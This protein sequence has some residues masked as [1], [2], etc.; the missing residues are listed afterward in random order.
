MP[1]S[2]YFAPGPL[3][4]EVHVPGSKSET[5]RALVLAALSDTP[6]RI[7][8]ALSSRDS[9][10]MIEALRS[11]G[12]TLD[13]SGSFIQV[14]APPRLR[15][16]EQIDCGLAGTVMRFVPPLCL[17]TEGS[18]L[19]HGD[20]AASQRPMKGLL[21]GL[22]AL[23]AKVNTDQLPCVVTGPGRGG[24]VVVDASASSQFISGLLLVGSRLPG[25]LTVH[26]E[27]S[28]VP[29][30]PHIQMTI[31]MLTQRGIT[32]EE[33]DQ[34]SWRVAPGIPTGLDMRIEPDLTNASA[35]LAAALIAGGTVRVPG[36]PESTTQPGA[37]FIDIARRFGADVKLDHRSVIVAG[38][39]RPSAINVNLH[40]A[41]E[42]TP[43]VA[44]VAAVAHG[45][46]VISGVAHIRGHETNRI[47]AI[48]TE[49]SALGIHATET[50]DGMR[51]TGRE[52]FDAPS[53]AVNTYA[54]HRMAHM[55]ALLGLTIRGLEVTDLECVSKTMPDFP[56]RFQAMVAV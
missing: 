39:S 49:L 23:G 52:T 44:A 45:T 40:E 30:L 5:N 1:S 9:H 10:L 25:G 17:L 2:L 6:S 36:W 15:A 16:P 8:G 47:E 26:H 31:K 33:C 54:D 24:E 22:R 55:A 53:R 42:L 20:L 38:H 3:D 4:A 51:I 14:T 35:F 34:A 7:E 32:V 50:E 37:M 46:S 18:T 13:V 41:S 48:V 11:F 27:G 28:Q 56:A 29:S 21:D 19:F 43:V 12:V